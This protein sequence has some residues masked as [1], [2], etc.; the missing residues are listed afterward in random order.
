MST[1]VPETGQPMTDADLARLENLLV[2]RVLPNGGM[3]LEILD[4]F[5]S[6]VVVGP[7]PIAAD[8]YLADVWGER[9]PSW[10]S[11]AERSEALALIES[12]RRHILWRVAREPDEAGESAL[13]YIA[14]PAGLADGDDMDDVDSDFPVGAGW[15]VGFLHGVSLR[16]AAW[17]E[18]LQ[19]DEQMTEDFSW[20]IDL[21]D[22]GDDE[23][24]ADEDEDEEGVEDDDADGEAG[25]FD[26]DDADD[27]DPDDDE[28]PLD[29]QTRLDV[30]GSLPD[31]LHDMH[32]LRI[33][34]LRPQ[35]ARRADVPGR[36]DPC[37]CGSG[38][39]FKKCCGAG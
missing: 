20:L 14:L 26:A 21:A 39:K 10:V 11:E 36:N 8:E 27:L 3:T 25:A 1:A 33:D 2:E 5:L 37:P 34:E 29:L 12:L 32:C 38:A 16:D 22:T 30:I 7:A 35:P 6:A 18:R 31:M 13:P 9:E 4:G 24:D 23:I 15:A 19:D 28:G 17:S